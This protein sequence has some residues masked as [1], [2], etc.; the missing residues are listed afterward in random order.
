MGV[1][2]NCTQTWFAAS[3]HAVER[4]IERFKPHLGYDEAKAELY[5]VANSW[6]EQGRWNFSGDD[7]TTYFW[8]TK[9]ILATSPKAYG[10]HWII[11]VMKPVKSD[12]PLLKIGRR[13]RGRNNKNHNENEGNIEWL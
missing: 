5:D 10:Q 3:R 9:M 13:P 6:Y 12:I 8:N 4:Y 11:T 2:D 1:L 7:E